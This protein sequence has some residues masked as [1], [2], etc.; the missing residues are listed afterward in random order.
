MPPVGADTQAP[1]GPPPPIS[2]GSE[3]SLHAA[4]LYDAANQKPG[5]VPEAGANLGAI[6][7][8]ELPTDVMPPAPGAIKVPVATPQAPAPH[9]S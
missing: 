5:H 4:Q 9:R 3:A 2:V 6:K 8:E 1:Q 7:E